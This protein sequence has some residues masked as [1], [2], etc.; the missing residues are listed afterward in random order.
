MPQERA[1][2]PPASPVDAVR[3]RRLVWELLV[4]Q[5]APAP[6][7]SGPFTDVAAAPDDVVVPNVQRQ[8]ET[9]LAE[10][11]NPVDL[12]DA[13]AATVDTARYWQPPDAIEQVLARPA[14]RAVLA[15]F[16]AAV[17]EAAPR[18]WSAPLD[19]AT[20]HRVRWV[21]ARGPAEVP[22]PDLAGWRAAMIADEAR[23]AAH[24]EKSDRPWSGQWW[25]TPG[26]PTPATTRAA[27]GLPAVHLALVEDESGWT[28]A[29]VE[30]VE[31]AAGARVLEVTSAGDWAALVAD[32]PLEVTHSRRHDWLKTTGRT[33]RWFLPDFSVV[34]ETYDAVHVTVAGY[35]DTAGAAV[36]LPGRP[37][38]ATVLA[39]WS[40]DETWW[41]RSDLL[42]GR[43][44]RR[45][46][47]VPDAETPWEWV[48]G[49]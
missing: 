27:E 38:C 1:G 3:G 39:G 7:W 47:R 30:P 40:P 17:V 23:F 8:V 26:Y 16:A 13:L 44:G 29:D 36:P 9:A 34:A 35:L 46:E 41:L 32:H 42:T 31:V 49:D 43:T 33:G 24:H 28:A 6:S 21:D 10:V 37:D 14:V 2:R 18:W 20:Q 5:Y 48:P 22:E 45:W 15:P 25:S 11:L 12:R 4:P 19:P